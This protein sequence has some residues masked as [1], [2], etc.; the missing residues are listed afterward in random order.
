MCR[1]DIQTDKVSVDTGLSGGA[2]NTYE[3]SLPCVIGAGRGLNT[4]RYPTFPDVVKSKKKPVKKIALTDLS[5]D[6]AKAGMTIVGLEPLK[7]SR[8]P[9]EITGDARE[10]ALKIFKILKEEAKVI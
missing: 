1:L 2:T 3:M 4:P 9:K 6:A 5:I 8:E 7:Q 10:V